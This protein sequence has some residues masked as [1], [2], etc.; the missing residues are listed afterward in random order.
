M[1]HC[2]A[3]GRFRLDPTGSGPAK[4]ARFANM[5]IRRKCLLVVKLLLPIR[6]LFD[7]GYLAIVDSDVLAYKT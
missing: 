6:V 4:K 7:S 1:V 5:W 3:T 2:A